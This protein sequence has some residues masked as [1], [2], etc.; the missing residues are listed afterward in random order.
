MTEKEKTLTIY[1]DD[2]TEVARDI[3]CTRVLFGD[4]M[5]DYFDGFNPSN[6]EDRLYMAHE[7]RRYRAYANMCYDLLTKAEKELH[8]KGVFCYR[9]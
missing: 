8:E 5:Q 1:K 6:A 7:F 3:E 4:I 9:D 2:L